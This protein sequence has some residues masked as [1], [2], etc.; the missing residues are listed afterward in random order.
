M[1]AFLYAQ[2]FLRLLCGNQTELCRTLYNKR[3]PLIRLIRYLQILGG[4][5]K[6]FFR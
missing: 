6:E 5:L 1:R 3:G 2:T 4:I